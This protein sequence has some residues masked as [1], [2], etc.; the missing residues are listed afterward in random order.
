MQ[1]IDQTRRL[2]LTLFSMLVFG[3]F[4]ALFSRLWYLQVLAGDRYGDLAEGNRLRRVVV[5]APRG[6]IL[7]RN[8]KPLV[9]DRAA[10]SV[11]VKPSELGD[12]R[13]AVL[14]RLA[15]VLGVKQATLEERLRDYTGSP[16]RGVP[17]A[18]DVSRQV[19]F[20]LT[21]HAEDF[22]G[23]TPEVLAL[24][25]YPA[26]SLA[27]HVLGYVGE[28][29]SADLASGRFRG[30]KEGDQV[31]KAG[32]ELTY[33]RLLRGRPGVRDLEVNAKGDVVRT[34]HASEPVPGNDLRL[35]IDL[36]VQRSVE[37]ALRAGL[38]A[39]RKLPDASRGGTY[40]ARAA[41]AV[42][43]D[44]SDGSLVALASLPEYDPRKFVGG[45]SRKDFAAYSNNPDKPL[46]GRAVQS[47]YP[48]GS[49][50]KPITAAAALRTGVITPTTRY[51]CPGSYRLGNY[52][53]RDWKAS[54]HGSVALL[55]GLRESCDVYF[56]N[57]GAAFNAAEQQQ[58]DRGQKIDE[59]M[60]ATAR[61]FG[62]GRTPPLDLPFAAAGTV[63]DRAWRRSFW[64][65]NKKEY[66]AGD[67]ALYKELCRYG[68]RWQGG[69]DLNVAIGQGDVQ[70]SPLQ[71]ASAYGALANG[72]TV[73]APHVGKEVT[74][75]V[76]GK[77]LRT[78]QPKVASV[79]R[80]PPGDLDAIGAALRSVPA[81]GT[82]VSAFAGF[83]LD[84]FPVAGKTGTADLPPR[85]PFAWFASYAPV[86]NPKYV[87]VVMVEEGG[88][89]GES[90]APVARVI[91][92]KLFGLP[93][94][95][96]K[97]GNDR[98]G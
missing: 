89:G 87:V 11:T 43:L 81:A 50:W 96:P 78:I 18:E 27:A 12:Q 65:D 45:I 53:K 91:Y 95:G 90:A 38:D 32:V 51:T 16:L 66:C 82:A 64:E 72:G 79:V 86:G 98:S 34:L 37:L 54:G 69:D 6:R 42:V 39:A 60:Q 68:W 36:G 80:L 13:K 21:E 35:T 52:V 61:T 58:E 33:D 57:I 85:A 14:G 7:D 73:Y 76:G 1:R 49:T 3:L 88:H 77:R 24:R 28:V 97:T 30:R 9:R 10:W 56:Y 71:L 29:S 23:V 74:A 2:R 47:V 5:D 19:L 75:S 26:G 4:L 25:E 70:V 15:K 40:P 46:I 41:S 48:P 44:P 20:D 59:Q 31:G 84:R 8:G 55:D 93:T 94:T 62:F 22:P 83:P 17:V 63:P 92:E 67:S